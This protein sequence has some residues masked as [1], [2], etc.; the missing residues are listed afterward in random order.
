MEETRRGFIKKLSALSAMPFIL[1]IVTALATEGAAKKQKLL[2]RSSW[3]TLNIGDIG[4]TFGILELFKKHLP[5]VEVV[6]WPKLID[7][8]VDVLLAKKF[9]WVKIVNSPIGEVTPELKQAFDECSFMVH[10]SAA[11]ITANKELLMWWE[12]TKKPYGIYGVSLDEV[13]GEIKDIID[14]ASFIFCRDTESLK[15]LKTLNLKCPVQE[16]GPDATF[17][18]DVHQDEKANAFLQKAGLKKGEFICVIPRLRYTPFFQIKGLEPGTEEKR[19]YTISL[20]FKEIDGAKLREVITRWVTETGKKVLICAE[21]TYQVELGKETVYDLLPAEIKKNVVWRDSFWLPDEAASVYRQSL[22]LVSFE[23]HSP[24]I[25]F[26]DGIPSIHLKQ[27]SDTRKG[28]MWRDVGLSDWY[29]LID[30]TPGSQI[31]NTLMK[32]YANYAQSLK[33]MEKAKAY[34]LK[35]QKE[36]F[37][38]IKKALPTT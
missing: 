16:F 10:S 8:G 12:A 9:P 38:A 1:P 7:R 4:H 22:A 31:A 29:F 18:I 27:P 21:V 35:V 15:Y 3:Q 36:N 6:L 17:A 23:P 13:K 30:E 32:L 34:V 20:A 24:I 33:T 37:K 14:N 19:K 26:N 25:A 5:D 28:Q 2:L 11:Y